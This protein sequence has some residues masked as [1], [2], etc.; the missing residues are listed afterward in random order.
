MYKIMLVDDEAEV[1]ESILLQIPWEELGFGVVADA[2]NGEDALE[3]MAIQEPD[4]IITDIQMP[5]MTGLEFIEK[6][7]EEY[8][9]KEIVIFPDSANLNMR[10]RQSAWA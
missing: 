7:R 5:F 1:R 8:P 9:G 4:V 3:K 10:D 6:V 2:E